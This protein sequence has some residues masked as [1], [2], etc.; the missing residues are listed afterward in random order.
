MC[1]VGELYQ[2]RALGS[3]EAFFPYLLTQGVFLT[4][5]TLV[6]VFQV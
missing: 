4:S 1:W 3:W 6:L 2:L 5:V